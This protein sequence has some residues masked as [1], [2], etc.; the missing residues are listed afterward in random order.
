MPADLRLREF[1]RTHPGLGKRDRQQIGDLVFDVLRN[2]RLYEALAPARRDSASPGQSAHAAQVHSGKRK[3][4]REAAPQAE[5]AGQKRE[6][7]R[8]SHCS[9]SAAGAGVPRAIPS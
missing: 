8:R 3:P 9:L 2:L 5:V 7:W 1:F 4:G 6:C